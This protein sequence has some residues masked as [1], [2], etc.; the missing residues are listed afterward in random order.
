MRASRLHFHHRNNDA[1]A[2]QLL[3]GVWRADRA[4][5]SP[6]A[7]CVPA[8]INYYKRQ[9]GSNLITAPLQQLNSPENVIDLIDIVRDELAKTGQH[10]TLQELVDAIRNANRS[11]LKSSGDD[12]TVK[13]AVELALK[14]WLFTAPSFAD[15][16]QSLIPAISQKFAQHQAQPTSHAATKVRALSLDF[17]AKSLTRRGGFYLMWTSELSE[18]L[19]I[20][21]KEHVLV[22]CHAHIL[23]EYMAREERY[24]RCDGH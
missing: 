18:H 6:W 16:S 23:R 14:L 20:K 4:E 8:Y 1:V 5:G 12:K 11:W 2:L 15:L 19:M 3:E 9:V 22:F 24:V 21:G 10:S 13:N 7:T 17:S